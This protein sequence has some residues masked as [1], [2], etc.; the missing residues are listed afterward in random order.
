MLI[1]NRLVEWVEGKGIS[2]EADPRHTQL[3]IREILGDDN[4]DRPVA[5]P[6]VRETEEDEAAVLKHIEELKKARAAGMGKRDEEKGLVD[7][8]MVSRYRS[9]AT[10]ANCLA[11]D[12]VDIEL[13]V[14]EIARKMSAPE[15]K[16][17][18]KLKRLA[19]YLK[20]R[21]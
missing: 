17:E 19:R 8:G 1:L 12:R 13:A 21:P 16:D 15:D 3:L 10:R 9:L 7:C 5:T 14:K 6:G 2:Y 4:H 11:S 20:V 18:E